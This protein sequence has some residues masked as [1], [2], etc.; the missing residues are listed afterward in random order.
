[1]NY[2]IDGFFL[3]QRMTGIQRYAYELCVQLDAFAEK[4][5]I[6]IIVPQWAEVQVSFNNIKVVYWG[7]NKSLMWQQIDLPLYLL[8]RRKKGIFF[9]N[10][11]PLIYAKGIIALHDVSCKAN[12]H[13]F[14]SK[15]DRLSALWHRIHYFRAA[16]SKMTILTVSE[17]SKSE[18]RKYYKIE[19]NRIH[20]IYNAWQHMK[21][22][23]ASKDI[24]LKY[25]FLQD[26]NY[27]FSMSTLAPNK[28]FQWI[29]EAALNNPHM[30][31]AIAGGG[32]LK[33]VV[34]NTCYEELSNVVFLGYIS[35]ADAKA[36]MGRCRT[37][38]FP[39]FYEGFGIPPLEALACGAINIVV[40][41]TPCMHEIYGSCGT[42]INPNGTDYLID[43]APLSAQ[44]R[45]TILNKY[46]WEKSARKLYE[47]LKDL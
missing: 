40:S 37:F 29:I 30:Q 20:I 31:F 28:N 23:E 21:R 39:T 22:V 34:S 13:F 5:S 7:K 1:M 11:L 12:P 4:D 2:A 43:C 25:P 47:L 24:F 26:R 32:N 33:K 38:L 3:T 8:T 10:T 16:H 46:T 6:E 41:D 44:L 15:R 36:L 9:T 45:E 19:A 27:V 17:F 35:D 18:I 14:T 42:Y